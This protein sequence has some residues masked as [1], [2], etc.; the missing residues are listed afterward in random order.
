[1]TSDDGKSADATVEELAASAEFSQEDVAE[2][3]AKTDEEAVETEEEETEEVSETEEKTEPKPDTAEADALSDA[4]LALVDK[5]SK[6]DETEQIEKIEKMLTSGRKT[7]VAQAKMLMDALDLEVEESAPLEDDESEA[8]AM[9]R[10]G[11][12]KEELQ[13]FRQSKES[14]ARKES[15]ESWSEQLGTP[16]DEILKNKDF[17]KAYHKADGDVESKVAKAMK[18]YLKINP[19]AGSKKAKTLKL[20]TTGKSTDAP[21]KKGDI[22]LD[23]E[24]EGK[25]LDEINLS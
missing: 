18:A 2:A 23:A 13:E 1:M 8:E 5:Y 25:S 19:I 9:K 16:T 12:T 15:V 11:L 24:L 21:A 22:D 4:D 10:L 6:F 3:P 20:S 14:K 7:Q 17:I